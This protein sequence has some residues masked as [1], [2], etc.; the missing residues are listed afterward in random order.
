MSREVQDM[1]VKK[2]SRP[3]FHQSMMDICM[4]IA[5]RATCLHREQGAIIVKDRRILATGYNGAPSG[6]KDCLAYGFCNKEISKP[7]RA[8]GLHGESNAI[9]SA[10][11]SGVDINGSTM[12]CVYAPCISCCNT[13]KNAG[14][15]IVIYAYQ[16]PGFP[17]SYQ[18]L[19]ELGIEPVVL[20]DY[21]S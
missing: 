11:K 17:Q 12:Y 1:P 8:E 9:I 16:Y 21:L 5:K 10:A 2:Q 18:Y 14:I 15:V 4:T 7:C 13:V 19:R 20:E 3:D 6:M